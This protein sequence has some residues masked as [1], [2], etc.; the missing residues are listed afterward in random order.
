MNVN[1]NGD[2]LY[3]GSNAIQ[4]TDKIPV[5]VWNVSFSPREGYFLTRFEDFSIPDKIYGQDPSLATRYV[6]TFNHSEKNLGI[7]LVGKKGTGKTL[8]GKLTAIESGLPIIL[9]SNQWN[10][11]DFKE[12]LSS[13][14]QNVC[15]FVDE[16]EKIYHESSE[17]LLSI[18]DGTMNSHNLW[19]FTANDRSKISGY[20]MNRPGRIYYLKEYSV[21]DRETVKEIVDDKLIHSEY[22][23]DLLELIDLH[24]IGTM[25]NVLA[26]VNE[27]NLYNQSPKEAISYLNILP[28]EISMKLEFIPDSNQVKKLIGDQLGDFTGMYSGDFMYDLNSE[29]E[30][31]L[32]NTFNA[33]NFNVDTFLYVGD[34]TYELTG[35]IDHIHW[36][37]LIHKITATSKSKNIKSIETKLEQLAY[38]PVYGKLICKKIDI[39]YQNPFTH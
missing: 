11:N 18:L 24:G 3:I 13:I 35:Y 39:K 12:F 29:L 1:I 32:T 16:F 5:G 23:N 34:S 9:I 20:L 6:N 19:I 4:A 31:Y 22:S 38:A 25:D 10:D 33:C 14:D 15:F 8:L 28:D 2:K 21:L 37:G 27:I 17:F 26:L 7:C 36:S 30:I